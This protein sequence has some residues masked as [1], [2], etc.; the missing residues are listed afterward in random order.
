MITWRSH[1]K[2]ERLNHI[3]TA[4][5]SAPREDYSLLIMG[6]S[7]GGGDGGEVDGDGFRGQFPTPAGCRNRVLSPE[8]WFHR[9]RRLRDFS[10]KM[11]QVLRVFPTR[12]IYGRRGGV[13]GGL[14]RQHACQA[15]AR[16]W[17]RLGH[18]LAPG[19]PPRG[20]LPAVPSFREIRT[21]GFSPIKFR[22]YFLYNFSEIQKQ[23]KKEL[24]LWHLVNRL[25][26]ENAKYYIKMHIKHVGSIIKQAWSI[27]N[28][29]YICNVSTSPSLT[30]ARPE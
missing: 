28:Y 16:P 15:R 26:P 24:A 22:E 19:W 1:H 6:V 23:Q 13:G 30:A 20:L 8:T 14:G 7:N 21:S 11:T 4:K 9:R 29:R 5:P 18:V 12:R 10:W 3:A 27:K 25:V 17:P 2:R